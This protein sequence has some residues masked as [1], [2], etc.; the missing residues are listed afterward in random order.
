MAV[1]VA[2]LV[3][4]EFVHGAEQIVRSTAGVVKSLVSATNTF[5]RMESVFITAS[6]SLSAARVDL[7]ELRGIT[8]GLGISFEGAAVPFAKFA[9]SADKFS[10][11]QTFEIFEGFST[12]LSAIHAPARTAEGA[13][14]ALQQ[15]VSK[16]KLSM[17][18][19]RRQLA[20]HIPGAMTV[21]Q[22][23]LSL[24]MLLAPVTL[25]SETGFLDLQS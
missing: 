22:P 4:S 3:A 14:L 16:G 17:Q 2:S 23:I 24:K 11:A 8:D 20:E 12:A 7:Q 1:L 25:I 15:I 9:A 19:L 18:D 21:L 6:G 13:F 5:Q 10:R